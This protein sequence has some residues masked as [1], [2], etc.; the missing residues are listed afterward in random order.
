MGSA[1]DY[2][3]EVCGAPYRTMDGSTQANASEA[4]SIPV[5]TR[6]DLEAM[7]RRPIGAGRPLHYQLR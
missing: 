1:L 3:A 2:M 7:G 4:N 6:R 5:P